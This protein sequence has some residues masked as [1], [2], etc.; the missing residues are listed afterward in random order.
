MTRQTY[1]RGIRIVLTL[2]L[3]DVGLFF[4]CFVCSIGRVRYENLIRPLRNRWCSINVSGVR[5]C[6]KCSLRKVLLIEVW[7]GMY[8]D[9]YCI[10][11]IGL[12]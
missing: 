3:N 10:E 12:E 2:P 5:K 11:V 4:G 9:G 6:R 1:T 7:V 8:V